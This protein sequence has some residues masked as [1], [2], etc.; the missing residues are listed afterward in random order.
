VLP[1]TAPGARAL[2]ATGPEALLVAGGGG[3][4]R[5]TDGGTTFATRA[6]R[7]VRAFDRAGGALLAYGAKALLISGD[8]GTSWRTLRLPPGGPVLSADFVSATTGFVVRDDGEVIATANGGRSWKLL[9]G[10][11]RDDIAQVSFGDAKHGFL[12][13]D[14][15]SGLGGV[16]RTSDAGRSWRPQVIGQRPLAQVLALGAAGGTALTNG[17]G[18]LFATGSGGDAGTRSALTLRVASKR[19]AGRRTAVT[20]AGRLKPA[21]AGAGVSVTARIGGTWVR[22]F[23]TVSGGGRFRTTWRLRG[24]TVF[25]AQWR[26]APGVQA[27]GTA[28]VRVRVG[29]HKRR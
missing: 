8:G 23:V 17:L 26:G 4:Q 7:P 27:D 25:V 14:S 20:L 19:R 21:P 2:L 29:R 5:S 6:R 12:M 22:K 13:L 10:V 9:T 15:D 24:G 16:L 3:V 28:A 18:Q 1:G 11:G